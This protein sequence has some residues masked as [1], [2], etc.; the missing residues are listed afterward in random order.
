MKLNGD[1]VAETG[2]TDPPPF[3]EIVTLVA[4]P[5]KV[6]PVT[7]I[8]VIPQV[9]PDVAPRVSSGGV[10]QPQLTENSGPVVEHPE[11]LRTVTV[12]VPFTTLL[13][14]LPVCQVPASRRYSSPVS[15]GLLTVTTAWLNPCVQS[16]VWAG[17]AGTGRGAFTVNDPE[18]GET[19]PAAFDTVKV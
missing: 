11:V 2:V 12:W 7:V 9:L 3:S 4:L 1:T 6:F 19:H 18:A 15:D 16:T 14:I 17:A 13:K 10:T 8:G 5:P